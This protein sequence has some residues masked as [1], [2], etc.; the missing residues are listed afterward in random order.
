[1]AYVPQALEDCRSFRSRTSSSSSTEICPISPAVITASAYN[2]HYLPDSGKV[3]PVFSPLPVHT[4]PPMQN[5][6][7]SSDI[8]KNISKTISPTGS[9]SAFRPCMSHPEDKSDEKIARIDRASDGAESASQ[10]I[11]REMVSSTGRRLLG[12]R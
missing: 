4:S 12:K 11:E 9:L 8:C 5:K 1:M 10:V 2:K 6:D 7:S 3:S